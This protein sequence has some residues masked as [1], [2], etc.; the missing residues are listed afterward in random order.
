MNSLPEVL[1]QEILTYLD[2]HHYHRR[3]TRV[4]KKQQQLM[5]WNPEY[6]SIIDNYSPLYYSFQWVDLKNNHYEQQL[7]VRMIHETKLNRCNVLLTHLNEMYSRKYYKQQTFTN[8]YGKTFTKE[9]FDTRY[10]KLIHVHEC[11]CINW[12]GEHPSAWIIY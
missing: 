12:K 9:E 11:G 4:Q 5:V 7:A 2:L 10:L 8:L 1:I 3:F 6:V